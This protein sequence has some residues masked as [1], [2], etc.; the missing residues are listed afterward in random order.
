MNVAYRFSTI[1]EAAITI[2]TGEQP[3]PVANGIRDGRGP[4]SVLAEGE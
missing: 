4:R 1:L 2:K 3:Y